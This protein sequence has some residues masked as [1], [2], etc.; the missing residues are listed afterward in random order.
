[1]KATALYWWE[2][3]NYTTMTGD[4]APT[5]EVSAESCHFCQDEIEVL[6]AHYGAGRYAE[7]A[8]ATPTIEAIVSF[9]AESQ[10]GE[11]DISVVQEWG[12]VYDSDGSTLNEESKTDSNYTEWKMDFVFDDV[13][14]TW[15][16]NQ[17]WLYV[18]DD[19]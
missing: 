12:Y 16:V 9:D 7:G 13:S 4:T 5:E 8:K 3:Y 17:M 6:T 1:M 18:D 10:Q 11:V 15:R 14:D 2:A 19:E